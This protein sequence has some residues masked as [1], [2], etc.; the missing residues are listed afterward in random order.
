MQNT[1]WLHVVGFI[2]TETC[3]TAWTSWSMARSENGYIRLLLSMNSSSVASEVV[4]LTE[5]SYLF[6][7][8]ADVQTYTD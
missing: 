7:V 6:D 1:F 3:G 2:L 5:I 8:T 4:L